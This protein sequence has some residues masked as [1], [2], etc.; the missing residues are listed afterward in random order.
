MSAINVALRR[1]GL[2]LIFINNF[3]H[4]CFLSVSLL[5]HRSSLVGTRVKSHEHAAFYNG[6]H[7]LFL[8]L[9]MCCLVPMPCVIL[10]FG[11][12]GKI[13]PVT[14]GFEIVALFLGVD[15]DVKFWGQHVSFLLVG[16]IIVSSIRNLLLQFMKV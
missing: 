15:I 12:L 6:F 4:N 16:I 1:V 5:L 2:N 8:F 3:I 7:L 9:W 10:C 11:S 13:D 14:R